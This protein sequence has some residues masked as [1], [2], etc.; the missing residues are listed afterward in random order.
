MCGIAGIMNLSDGLPDQ[1]GLVKNMLSRIQY[2]GPDE[3]G[4]YAGENVYLG[5]VRLSIIDLSSG[6]QP[7]SNE[8][9]RFWIVFNGEIFNYIELRQQLLKKNYSFKTTS[10]TEVLLL[11]YEEYGPKCLNM[12][13][14]QFAFAIWDKHKKEL[15]LARDRMGIRPLFYSYLGNTFIFGSE[16]KTIL[17]H[18]DIVPEFDYKTLKQVFTIWAPISPNTMFKNILEL[19]P[20][21][22]MIVS[23]NEK[24]ILRYW[25]LNYPETNEG[26]FSG[27]M[28][29]A[30][31]QLD[32]LLTD[33][34]RLRLRAD[35]PVAAYLSGGIDS[36]A[37]TRYIK[38]L[39]PDHCKP[40]PLDLK[41][42]NLMK[43]LI[44]MKFQNF[45][46]PVMFP[47][48]VRTMK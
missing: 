15:F 7:L 45:S 2:R 13:N 25:G 5:S 28:N 18:P 1:T 40:I 31:E 41:I 20:G 23:K 22:Y 14:G 43:L 12:L 32:E 19:S 8:N 3:S 47:L 46:I 16:I 24:K 29:E 35:V 44:K 36:S 21:H 37:T 27:S 10:D 26:F 33:A 9:N 11:L 34:V 17:E 48:L 4:I 39:N 38:K 30:G 6:Q 42:M